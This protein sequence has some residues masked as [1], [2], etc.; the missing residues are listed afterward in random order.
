MRDRISNR[1][2]YIYIFFVLIA[3]ILVSRLYSLQIV[4][5][6]EY[7]QKAQRQYMT[8][9]QKIFDRGIIYLQD[10]DGDLVSAAMLKNTYDLV[11][12]NK[13]LKNPEDA[14]NKI[15]NVISLNEDDFLNKSSKIGDP[16]EEI[17]KNLEKSIA[18]KIIAF[19]IDGV[20]LERKQERYYP[21]DNLASQTI[22]LVAFD[23]DELK[24]RYG[25]ERYYDEI[26]SSEN[27]NSYVNFFAEVFSADDE[28]F[29][30]KN[31]GDL[32]LTIE[33]N[34]QAFLELELENIMKTLKTKQAGGIVID[35]ISG[36]IFAMSSKPDFNPNDLSNTSINRLS[37]PL[38]ES[39]YE[40]G[41]IIKP[42][43]VAAGL[44]SGAIRVND[45]YNDTGHI[46]VDGRK[47]S[48]YDGKARG[49]VEMQEILNQSLNVGVS[50]IVS[51]MGN[52]TFT[53]Y[54]KKLGLGE[55]TG[56]DLP[57]E[58]SGLISNL[59]S[60]RDIEHMTA[61]FG[62]GIAMTP[63]ETVKALCTLANGGRLVTPHLVKEIR[64]SF[65]PKKEI[66]YGFSGQVFSKKTSQDITGM[67]IKVVDEALLGGT[68]NMKNYS[69]AAKT[70][71]A[72]MA[73]PSGG[74]YEDKF[75]HSFFGY[76]PALEPRFLV[77]LYAVEPQGVKYA[78]GS[79]TEPFI[80]ITR[81]LIN[82]YQINPD[83]L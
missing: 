9:S 77:F 68:V 8:S 15:S 81:F 58:T 42:L 82:Y 20:R 69:I 19:D 47:I 78:S 49:V 11:I 33:P 70:G 51:K 26:L 35:P 7:I 83:R 29:E 62:Q 65:A 22:G 80:N 21:G 38:V 4:H 18:D 24:G 10:K 14:F 61:S 41:S 56:V 60:K 12:N 64:Y 79:L 44:D 27:K 53:Q 34:A 66:E 32:V 28:D 13:N 40:M 37:N 25:I 5:G 31:K 16:H 43:T 75:L 72:Q 45:T 71:T 54:F 57:A 50:Y 73:S 2:K 74:Y 63:M 59:D 6:E 17:A 52:E 39:V 76:F 55:K 48:N 36:E 46:F 1:V 67:L 23:E 3:L 30:L